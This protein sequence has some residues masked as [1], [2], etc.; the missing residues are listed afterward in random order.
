[1]RRNGN[2]FPLPG[3]L[4][5]RLLAAGLLLGLGYARPANA[6]T[7][8][9]LS[10]VRARGE[11]RCGVS[12][13]I[14]GFSA[15]GEDGQ[16][17]GMD[18]DF[19]RAVAIAALGD[20]NKVKFVPLSALQR[21]RALQTQSIDLL[22]RTT[23]WT[24]SR[25]ANFSVVFAGVTY[26][27]SQGIMLRA[28]LPGSLEGRRVC[29][30]SGTDELDDITSYAQ[31]KNWHLTPVLV[32][33]KAEQMQK[34]GSGACDAVVGDIS[35]LQ[36]LRADLPKPDAYK[37]LPDKIAK[38]P[39]GPLVRW[40]DG[41]WIVLTRAVYAVLIDADERGL[42][43]KE[44]QSMVSG[45]TLNQSETDYLTATNQIGTAL[46][47]SPDWAVQIIA[48]IGNYGEMFNRNLGKDSAL[49]M[50]PGPN[51]PWTKGGLLYAPPL[52]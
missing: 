41:Q 1:M 7:G 51:Q 28:D 38:E 11:L 14:S 2:S 19:C 25:E 9:T 35:S 42:T 3:R 52:Q 24:V 21:F 44:A 17:H 20:A 16:W 40:D 4:A 43:Q 22:T 36:E 5:A 48:N 46:G 27:D 23:T 13:G 47:L 33:D 45:G 26:Y 8:D 34:L 50:D 10:A 30:E 32:A 12:Q 31:G 6:E 18:A 49:N 39:L 29:I 15:K 37:I